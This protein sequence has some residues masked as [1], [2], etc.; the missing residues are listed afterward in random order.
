[1]K[2]AEIKQTVQTTSGEQLVFIFTYK[3]KS[4]LK[5]E[6]LVKKILMARLEEEGV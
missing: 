3:E 2:G 6:D 4:T 5:E 1:M